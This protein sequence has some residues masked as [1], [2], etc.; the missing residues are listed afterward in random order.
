MTHY[1]IHPVVP[2]ST[3]AKISVDA[4]DIEKQGLQKNLPY[5]YDRLLPHSVY[6]LGLFSGL[7]VVTAL[8]GVIVWCLAI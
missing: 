8:I 2:D 6:Q 3:Q 5:L 1:R 4:L 7:M